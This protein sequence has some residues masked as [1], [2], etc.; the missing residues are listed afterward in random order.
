MSIASR[1][2]GFI[3]DLD[4]VI[5]QGDELLRGAAQFIKR[6][7]RGG[8]PLVFVTNNASRTPAEWVALFER[9]KVK[10]E[11][12]HFLTSAHA[13][14]ALLTTDPLPRCFVIGEFGVT[15]TLREAG[16]EVVDDQ[17]EADTVVVSWD[18]GL[19]YEKLRDATLAIGRGAR[20]VATNPDRVLPSAD[21]PVP[22]SGA[23]IA[24]LREATRVAPEIAG[25]PQSLLFELAADRLGVN[26]PILVVGD[27]IDTDVVA[28][29]SMGFDSALVLT[30]VSRWTSMIG[31]RVAP[32][33]VVSKIAD[34]DG[35]EPPIVRPAREAD[36]SAIRDLL[37]K[38]NFDADGAARR[39]RETLVAEGP[40]G[41]VVGTI[42]WEMI[43]GAAHLRG[44]CVAPSERAHGAGSHLVVRA[45]D[46]LSRSD[47]DWVY[48]LTPGADGLFEKL[49]FWRVHRDR[50]PD[51][52]LETATYGEAASGG[53]ALVRR[54][55]D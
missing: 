42:A 19:T 46:Q 32:T 24:F 12:D 28:A 20:F 47:I 1:Y 52:V 13:L 44:I 39:L 4:G 51:E 55:R 27:Q 34:L 14:A 23:T 2:A 43:E 41:K 7:R 17:R 6:M 11:D 16:I 8:L 54:L 45:L 36:L 48:L 50:V 10:V 3:V 5:V 21:G 30:G 35:P 18:R 31:A 40:D 25:K 49:G 53:I 37:L 26:G 22:G 9:A 29:G 38:Q 15:A 33:W